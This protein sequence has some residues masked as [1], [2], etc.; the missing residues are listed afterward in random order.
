[1][2]MCNITFAVPRLSIFVFKKSSEKKNIFTMII[3]MVKSLTG[4]GW[5]DVGPAS[6]TV[7]Q[8]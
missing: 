7:A 2:N 3:F 1:M 4:F 5:N 8:Q 6:Q